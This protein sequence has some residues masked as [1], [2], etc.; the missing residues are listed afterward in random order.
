MKISI[1]VAKD[2]SNAIGKNNDLMWRLPKDMHYFKE[3][4]LNHCII[5]GRKNYFSIPEKFRPLA[6]RTNIVVSSQEGLGLE[7]EVLLTHSIHEAL[8]IAESKNET[9]VFIIGG[10]QIYAQTIGLANKLYI[11]EVDATFPDADTFFPQLDLNQWKE[12]KRTKHF[13]DEKN[14]YNFDFVE[15]EKQTN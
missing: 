7:K 11:T 2:Q 5:T 10:G 4:T 12:T 13:A 9:E 1:I 14:I 6:N 15:Y 3:K 8:K